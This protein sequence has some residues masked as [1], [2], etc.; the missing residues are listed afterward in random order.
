[1]SQG[2]GPETHFIFNYSIFKK[3]SLSLLFSE[4][5][6]DGFSWDIEQIVHNLCSYGSK[7]CK[8]KILVCKYFFN[9][10][11]KTDFFAVIFS[12]FLNF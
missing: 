9:F 5:A 7:Y 6:Y 4:T 10:M 8:F 11:P 1:M 12:I 3:K 2:I